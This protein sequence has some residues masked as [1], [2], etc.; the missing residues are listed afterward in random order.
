MMSQVETFP[1]LHI[2]IETHSVF[3][4]IQ[5]TEDNGRCPL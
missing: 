3:E 1:S 2:M 4:V 5:E